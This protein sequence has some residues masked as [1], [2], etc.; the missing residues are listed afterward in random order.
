MARIP[1]EII[2]ALKEP[3]L[4]DDMHII[5]ERKHTMYAINHVLIRQL[6]LR[7]FGPSGEW[8]ASLGVGVQEI[9]ADFSELETPRPVILA[10]VH[11]AAVLTAPAERISDLLLDTMTGFRAVEPVMFGAVDDVVSTHLEAPSSRNLALFGAALS[12]SM[13]LGRML[14]ESGDRD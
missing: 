10:G 12:H 11:T 14:Y 7:A 2:E 13:Q 9:V 4:L 6:A 3:D 1:T 8:Y 5:A